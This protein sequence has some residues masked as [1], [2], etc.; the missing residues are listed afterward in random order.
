MSSRPRHEVELYREDDAFVVIA[1]LDDADREDV[2]LSWHDGELSIVVESDEADGDR[3][4]VRRRRVGL[5]RPIEADEITAS[6]DDGV[7]EVRLPIAE[8]SA[9]TGQRIEIE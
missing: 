8:E 1:D 3:H 6:F 5:H 9:P 7:L 2:E 4:Q